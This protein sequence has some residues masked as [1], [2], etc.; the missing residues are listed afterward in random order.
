YYDPQL[1]LWHSI[2]P[3]DEFYSPYVYVGNNP[4]FFVDP[5]GMVVIGHGASSALSRFG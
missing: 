1:G 2:D 4:I 3:A 5:D